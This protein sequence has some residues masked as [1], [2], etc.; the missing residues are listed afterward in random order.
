[1]RRR[2]LAF[3]VLPA[4]LVGGLF[5]PLSPRGLV[6]HPH[7]ARNYE[8]ALT[9][10]AAIKSADDA[11]IAPECRTTLYTYG[12]RTRHVVV[13][14]HGLTNCPAQFD[15]LGHLVYAR[16]ANVLIP[17]IPRHGFADRMTDQL[18]ESDAREWCAFADSVVDAARGLGDS[19][20]VVGLS[21]GGTLAAWVAQERRDVDRAVLIAPMIGVAVAPGG[22][23]PVVTRLAALLPNQFVWWN[24][25]QRAALAGPKHV[26][27]RF[28]SRAVAATLL[29]GG[30]ILQ[31]AHERP[32]GARRAAFITVGGDAAVD[33]GAIAELAR[34]W[35]KSRPGTV[36]ER[37]EFP[38]ERR[39]SHDVVDPDQVGGDP[40]FTYPVL[41][42]IIGP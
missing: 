34:L 40:A 23:T 22:W 41:E 9:R 20:T 38:A 27:P 4:L 10:I 39:L 12:S 24:S 36:T 7:P 42:R 11:R 1:M 15:S 16:G 17:R 28:A 3:L 26:Y 19:V 33:N 30:A 37:F 5:L 29:I 13:L 35:E 8:E 2:L 31:S 14:F 32:P 21:L 6:S 18:A 25:R